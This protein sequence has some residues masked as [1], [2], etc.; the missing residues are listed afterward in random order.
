MEG[1]SVY[2]FTNICVFYGSSPRKDREFLKA[3]HTFDQVL[4]EK[5]IHLVFGGGSLGLMGVVSLVAHV[6]GSNVLGIIPKALTIP[7]ITRMTVGREIQVSTM[8]ERISKMLEK[9]D[10]FIALPDGYARQILVSAL[11][12]DELIDKLQSFVHELDPVMAQLDWS[13]RENNPGKR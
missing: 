3:V 6:G 13:E 4:A 2:R 5:K 9:S 8:Y 1:A 10:T 11:T 12:T 7:N